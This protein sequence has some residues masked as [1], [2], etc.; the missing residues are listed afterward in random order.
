ASPV[1]RG[2]SLVADRRRA[3]ELAAAPAARPRTGPTRRHARLLQPGRPDDPPRAARP[4]TALLRALGAGCESGQPAP[5]LHRLG[6]GI[7]PAGPVGPSRGAGKVVSLPRRGGTPAG[8]GA[9]GGRTD[10]LPRLEPD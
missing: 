5:T 8:R 10:L 1:P 9:R 2:A 4:G 7:P 3:A 6:T